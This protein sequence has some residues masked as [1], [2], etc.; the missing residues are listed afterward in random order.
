MPFRTKNE[1]G[2]IKCKV[3]HHI[4]EIKDLVTPDPRLEGTE[5]EGFVQGGYSVDRTVSKLMKIKDEVDK[6]LHVLNDYRTADKFYPQTKEK[7]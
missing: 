1:L 7:T 3:D 4:K 5:L 6:A 2:L